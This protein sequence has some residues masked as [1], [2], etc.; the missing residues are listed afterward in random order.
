METM[1][2]IFKAIMVIAA[3]VAIASAMALDSFDYFDQIFK[4][5]CISSFIAVGL[6][7]VVYR[8]EGE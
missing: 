6:G 1:G 5:F 3:F 8:Y 2:R 4:I 7:L